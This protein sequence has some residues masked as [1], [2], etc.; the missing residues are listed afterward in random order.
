[1]SSLSQTEHFSLS[2]GRTHAFARI[3]SSPV[4]GWLAAAAMVVAYLSADPEQRFGGAILSALAFALAQSLLPACRPLA[5]APLC[6]WNWAVFL[7]FLEL[8]ILPFSLLVSGPS[9]GVLPQLPASAAINAAMGLNAVAFLAFS[10]TYQYLSSKR[11]KESAS[12]SAVPRGKIAAIHPSTRF[13]ACYVVLGLFGLLLAFGGIGGLL[14]YFV[15]PGEYVDLFVEASHTLRGVASLLLRPFLG[16]GLVILWC[17]WIDRRAHRSS[18]RWMTMVTLVAMLGVLLSYATFSYNRG[19]FVVPL[20]AMLAVLLTCKARVSFG[21]LAVAGSVLLVVLLLAPFIAIYRNADLT[22]NMTGRDLFE[23]PDTA[24]LLAD[25]INPLESIQMYGAGPQYLG[26]LLEASRWGTRPY[27]GS[28]IIPSVLLPLP[29]LGRMFRES[30]GQV[31]YNEMIYGTTHIFD[32]NIPLAGEL[33]LNF[34]VFG[35]IAGFSLLGS[36]AYFLQRGFER[37]TAAIEVYVWQY[38]AVWILFLVIVS[39]TVVSQILCYF[40]WPIYSYLLWKRIALR[41]LS[42]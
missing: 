27:L 15:N 9:I 19:A 20:V 5:A 39:V 12:A 36:V 37:A 34:H 40:F 22:G 35:I 2:R 24:G 25:K 29:V 42:A 7:F 31:I 21:V 28:T 6:P 3:L 38:S 10:A 16:F 17:A 18:P 1:M 26:F 14:N 33:F 30:S 8:V 13:V 4:W 32:Q 11:K 23:D 41:R